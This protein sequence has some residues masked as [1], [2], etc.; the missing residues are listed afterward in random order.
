MLSSARP[1]C[2]KIHRYQRSL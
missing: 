2:T 1:K